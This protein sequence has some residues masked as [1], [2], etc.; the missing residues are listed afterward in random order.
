MGRGDGEKGSPFPLPSRSISNT[1]MASS[2][3]RQRNS[4]AGS[5]WR[6]WRPGEFWGHR[7]RAGWRKGE[8]LSAGILLP[9][10]RTAAFLFGAASVS[11]G[12]GGVTAAFISA[13]LLRSS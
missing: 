10:R 13:N 3:L 5:V 1:L 12:P 8:V 7:Q 6:R 2:G 11:S 9:S 4:L